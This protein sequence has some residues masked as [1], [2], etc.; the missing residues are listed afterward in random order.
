M[1][2]VSRRRDSGHLELAVET[3]GGLRLGRRRAARSVVPAQAQAD[4][5]AQLVCR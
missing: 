5:I 3:P 4:L 2:E 1:S